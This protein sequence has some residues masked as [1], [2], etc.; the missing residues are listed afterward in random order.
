MFKYA[1]IKNNIVLNIIV[2]END[3]EFLEN[4]RTFHQVDEIVE[5]KENC[6]IGGTYIDGLFYRIPASETES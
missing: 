5:S 6:E 1:L 4:L 2:S 3:A